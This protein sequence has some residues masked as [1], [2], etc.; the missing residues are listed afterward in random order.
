MST[1]TYPG[2]HIGTKFRPSL[3]HPHV[4]RTV[5]YRFLVTPGTGT[6][7]LL[8]NKQTKKLT[9]PEQGWFRHEP[10]LELIAYF[11]GC[12]HN[13]LIH[14]PVKRYF[15]HVSG[16]LLLIYNQMLPRQVLVADEILILFYSC[17][18]TKFS[19]HGCSHG[20]RVWLSFN[21]LV[22]LLKFS[23]TG[24]STAMGTARPTTELV[25]LY[26]I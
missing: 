12:D 7:S 23:K 26:K 4:R 20:C 1:H 2:V 25:Q 13:Q 14:Q 22:R 9:E 24:R 17:R 18:S 8:F 6:C 11:L 16:Y 21:V 19:S 10:L 3:S 5:K 15:W